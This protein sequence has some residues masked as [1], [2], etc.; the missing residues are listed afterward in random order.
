MSSPTSVAWR[1]GPGDRALVPSVRNEAM[2]TGICRVH[3]LELR[4]VHGD[5]AGAEE[6]IARECADLAGGN[7]WVA[8][9]GFYQLGELRRRRGDAAGAR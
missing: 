6:L 7:P 3:R 8:G 2:Y 9:E 4:S 1:T 5:W